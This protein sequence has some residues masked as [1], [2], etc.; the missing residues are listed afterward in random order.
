[1]VERLAD[2]STVHVLYCV[3]H[4]IL[5]ELT[6]IMKLVYNARGSP[7]SDPSLKYDTNHATTISHSVGQR[8][9]NTNRQARILLY[10]Y[11]QYSISTISHT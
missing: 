5:A 11:V 10:K 3:G 2:D 1:M 8:F 4:T 7:L 6:P 9:L